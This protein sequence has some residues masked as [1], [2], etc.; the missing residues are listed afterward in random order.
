MFES[1]PPPRK[2]VPL[3]ISLGQ[4]NTHPISSQK[5]KRKSNTITGTLDEENRFNLSHNLS[6]SFSDQKLTV[7]TSDLHIDKSPR[8][9]RSINESAANPTQNSENCNTSANP[10]AHNNDDTTMVGYII[11][12]IDT[13]ADGLKQSSG[14]SNSSPNLS[15]CGTEVSSVSERREWLKNFGEK[16]SSNAFRSILKDNDPD[17]IETRA[18]DDHHN[19]LRGCAGGDKETRESPPA[20]LKPSV[21]SNARISTTINLPVSHHSSHV[22]NSAKKPKKPRPVMNRRA[23][24]SVMMHSWIAGNKEEVKATDDGYAS[25]ASLSK[26]LENDPTSEKKKRHVR[27]GRNI[28]SKSRQFEKDNENVIIMENHISRGAVGDKKKWLQNA[29]HSTAEEDGDDDASSYFSGYVKSDVGRSAKQFPSYNRPGAQTEI[30]TDDAASSLSVADKKDWLKKAFSQKSEER[31][32]LGY[33]KAQTDVMHNR[34]ELRDEAASRAKLRFKERSSRKLLGPTA[35]ST[36]PALKPTKRTESKH[37]SISIDTSSNPDEGTNRVAPE[38]QV[39][40]HPK[41]V[42]TI[43]PKDAVFRSKSEKVV[44]TSDIAEDNTQMD[45]RSARDLLVQRSNKNGHNAQ[46]VNKVF[47]RKKKFEKLEEDSRRKSIGVGLVLKT[48]WDLADTSKGRPSNIYEK[49]YVPSQDIAPK[50]SFEELP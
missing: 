42:P 10:S 2:T 12:T 8:I 41:K 1:S 36:R 22:T 40:V 13:S 21:N 19:Y 49:K 15:E 26:W 24:S 44:H 25:V 30:I 43:R 32:K 4:N 14:F 5:K 48:S 27:R 33:T 29:F 37:K 7:D 23:S 35:A 45:F 46:V 3:R 34:G 28:I 18:N 11:P 20:S 38:K 9:N 17:T 31:K 16:Q 50:K 6:S 39:L 47:L